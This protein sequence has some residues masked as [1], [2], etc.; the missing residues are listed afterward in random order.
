MPLTDPWAFQRWA[1]DTETGNPIRKAVLSMLAMMADTNTGRCEALQETIAKG[2]EASER[3]VRG[4]LRSLE[5]AG[6]I[7]RREQRYY[8]GRRRGDEFLLLAPWVDGWPDGTKVEAKRQEV[9]PAKRQEV[10]PTPA[11]DAAQERPL[12]NDQREERADPRESMPEDFPS[13]L[14]PHARAVYSVLRQVAAQHPSAR[15]VWPLAVGRVVMAHPRHPLVATA[16]AL[17]VWAVDPPRPVKDVAATYRT[18]LQ[19]ERELESTERLTGEAPGA[20]VRPLRPRGQRAEVTESLMERAGLTVEQR[21][22]GG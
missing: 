10:P 2:V 22:S 12:G 5:E 18:F 9:P 3:A 20:N 1:F 17:A 15:R 4:H 7:A 11:P 13:E 19:R 14:L 8:D 6:T 21:P 16:H